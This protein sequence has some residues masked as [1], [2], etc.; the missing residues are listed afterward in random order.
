MDWCGVHPTEFPQRLFPSPKG[1]LAMTSK[2]FSLLSPNFSLNGTTLNTTELT[3]PFLFSFGTWMISPS[4]CFLNWV[5]CGCFTLCEGAFS[6][7]REALFPEA[8]L[9]SLRMKTRLMCTGRLKKLF[10][11]QIFKYT[12]LHPSLST[13]KLD[14]LHPVSRLLTSS[15]GVTAL[16]SSCTCPRQ[17]FG[18]LH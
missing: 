12:V 4:G 10:L 1:T 2:Y 13:L 3:P 17:K 6:S 14:H 15:S 9:Q 11:P 16:H 8:T 18:I 5:W 7:L